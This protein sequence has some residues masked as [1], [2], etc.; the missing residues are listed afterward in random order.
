[1]RIRKIYLHL[2]YW[3]VLYL[4][5]IFCVGEL[6]CATEALYFPTWGMIFSLHRNRPYEYVVAFL[7]LGVMILFVYY[8]HKD[9]K[10]VQNKN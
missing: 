3:R 9:Y 5:I 8:Y 4:F 2:K 7:G 1:M 10:N 6:L